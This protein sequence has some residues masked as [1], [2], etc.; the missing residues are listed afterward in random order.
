MK[1]YSKQEEYEIIQMIVS[2][3][4]ELYRVLVEQYQNYVYT[5]AY[6]ILG[7]EQ[8]AED[9]SQESFVKAYN[10]LSRF[11]FDSKFSTWLYR[12]V[13]NTAITA[14]R[15]RKYFEQDSNLQH[16]VSKPLD[17]IKHNE[18]QYFI[19]MGFNQLKEDD[20]VVLSLFYLKELHVKEIAEILNL[21]ENTVKVRIHRA[22]K[23]LAEKM[24]YLVNNNVNDLL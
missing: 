11:K 8:D 13:V 14:K 17:Q 16:C 20:V 22:R 2:G 18:Q 4:Q 9:V 6:K 5:A 12:I 21:E 3:N 1:F 7:H 10:H 23:K 15:K 19:Q 24:A